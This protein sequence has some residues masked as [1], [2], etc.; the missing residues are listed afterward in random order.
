MLA[1][2][3]RMRPPPLLLQGPLWADLGKLLP[4]FHIS[5]VRCGVS[6]LG[7]GAEELKE[8]TKFKE[9]RSRPWQKAP[10]RASAASLGLPPALPGGL[11][12]P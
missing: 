3:C 11:L 1:G 2:A 5:R 12:K 4:F 6:Y 8:P 10:S 7:S 9:Q